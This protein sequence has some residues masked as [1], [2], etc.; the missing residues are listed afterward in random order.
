MV[1]ES[2]KPHDRRHTLMMWVGCLAPLAIILVMWF[3]GV[4]QSILTFGIILLC[5]VTH[6]L[7]M[8]NMKHGVQDAKNNVPQEQKKVS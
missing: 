5:P 6:F 4:S 3:A 1:G 7:M 8:K 2:N